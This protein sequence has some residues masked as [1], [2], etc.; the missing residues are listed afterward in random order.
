MMYLHQ[1]SGLMN[2]AYFKFDIDESS[3][4]IFFFFFV[5]PRIHFF[6]GELDSTRA[7]PF[8][9]TPNIVEFVSSIGING[10]LTAS[11]IALARCYV[12]PNFKVTA[13]VFCS[14]K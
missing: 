14:R 5:L 1:D 11:M 4:E 7:V 6:L 13:I 9:L 2:V 8:R 10:P 3:G 12:Y